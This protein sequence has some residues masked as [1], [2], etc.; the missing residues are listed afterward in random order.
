MRLGTRVVLE[1]EA[2]DGDD[3]PDAREDDQPPLPQGDAEA[4]ESDAAGDG[5]GPV[6]ARAEEAQ[7]AGAV[8][9]LGLGVVLGALLE[10]SRD[11]AELRPD[12]QG[13][14]AGQGEADDADRRTR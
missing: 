14:A 7:V 5:D 3:E 6:A 1:D 4:G 10:A 12:D 11:E 9:D 8:G 13:E 2:A